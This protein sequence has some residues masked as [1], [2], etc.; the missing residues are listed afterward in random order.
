MRLRAIASA[1]PEHRY[2]SE[3]IAGWVGANPAFLRDKIGIAR[4][5]FLAAG[6][7]GLDLA[8]A[9]GRRLLAKEPGLDPGRVR[10]VVFVT[11]NPDYRIP[12]SAALFQARLG[13]PE[14]A[15]CFDL[16]LGCSGYVYGLAV[17]GALMAAAGMADGLLVTSDPYSRVMGRADRDTVTLFGD[18]A[19]VS[20][21]SAEAGGELGATDFGTDGQGWE[22]LAVRAGGGARPREG[23]F[24]AAAPAPDDDWRLRMNGRGIFNFMLKRVPASLERCLAANHLAR[25]A[26]D[27]F[28][29][30]QASR[31]L[32]ETLVATTGLP[33]EKVPIRLEEV[34]NT[35]SSSIPLVLEELAAEGKLAG[36]TALLSGFGVGLS[37][38]ST[39]VRF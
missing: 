5:G 24:P 31:F 18:G 38:A 22:H 2:A 10:L 15:A 25:E 4:R 12:H 36:R 14:T 19:T 37:W 20:W 3:E 23:L 13:L 16:S 6:E 26:V 32:L 29:F 30:H 34:G 8:L 7:T 39:V 9:A 1:L 27:W 33:A 28:V 35:V 11:Q 21:L 17:A